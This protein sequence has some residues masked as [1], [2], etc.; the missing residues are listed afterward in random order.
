MALVARALFFGLLRLLAG[1][2]HARGD[3]R[4]LLAQHVDDGAGVAVEADVGVVVADLVDDRAGE[5]FDI[6]PGAGGHFAGNDG[7]AGL[8]HGFAGDAG[9]FVLGQDG[10]EHGVG[11]L[12][13]DLVRMAFGHRF[14]GEEVA[15][16]RVYIL[17]SG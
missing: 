10:V 3:V 13:R 12:V 9:A 17:Q 6:D 8:H 7:C 16:H 14:G 15:G 4:R 2:V 1:A 11:N 5:G